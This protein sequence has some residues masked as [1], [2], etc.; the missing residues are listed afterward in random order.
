MGCNHSKKDD[1]VETKLPTDLKSVMGENL[2]HNINDRSKI[3]LVF[4]RKFNYVDFACYFITDI[5]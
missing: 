1:V 4:K 5:R 2:P 3:G